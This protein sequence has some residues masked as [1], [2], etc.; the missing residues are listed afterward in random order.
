[1][2]KLNLFFSKIKELT[3][4]QR[5]FFWRSVRNLSYDAFEEFKAFGKELGRVKLDLSSIEKDARSNNTKNEGLLNQINQYEKSDMQKA[6]HIAGL[7]SKMEELNKQATQLNKVINNYE[8]LHQHRTEEY[9]KKIVQLNQLKETLEKE[10]RRVNDERVQEKQDSFDKM[11]KQWAEHELSV[12]QA[13]RMVCQNHYVKYVDDVPFKGSPDNTVEICDEYIIFDSKCPSNDDLSNFPKYIKVQAESVKKYAGQEKVKKDIF[14]VVPAN[15]IHTIT[16]LSYNMGDYNVYVI[17]KDAVEPILLSLKRIEDYEFMNQ[18]SP[19]ERDNI[20]RVIGKFAHTTKRKIQVDQFFA[21]EFLQLL[22][23]CKNELP[24][25][26]LKQVIEYE[27][28][29]KLNPP[30]ERKTKQ[31]LTKELQ[32]KHNSI[33][34]EASIREVNIPSNFAEL[35]E[36]E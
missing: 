13:L 9:E 24:G 21:A 32:D 7:N 35:K 19:D 11:K 26:I 6:S 18:L 17:T 33:N 15:A 27:K 36:L 16:Q 8:N 34:A 5:L 30:P 14:L 10:V 4:W 31:I 29:E 22:A 3:F 23:R 12:K 28:A 1:M 2:E 20:C 25:D